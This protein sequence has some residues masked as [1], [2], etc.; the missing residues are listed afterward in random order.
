MNICGDCHA[1][2]PLTS[3]RFLHCLSLRYTPPLY[4]RPTVSQSHISSFLHDLYS[5]TLL[6]ASCYILNWPTCVE[7]A[8]AHDLV[9]KHINCRTH[10]TKTT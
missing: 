4:Q 10:A 9:A 5:P 6:L 1:Q 3:L 8:T 2:F 7:L